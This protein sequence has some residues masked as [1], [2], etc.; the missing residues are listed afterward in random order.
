MS[1]QMHITIRTNRVG[2]DMELPL[3][4][5]EDVWQIMTDDEQSDVIL[6]TIAENIDYSIST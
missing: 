2:S 3:G 5:T 1:K 4:Y 6:T